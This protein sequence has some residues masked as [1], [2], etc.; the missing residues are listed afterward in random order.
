MEVVDLEQGPSRR[1]AG[2]VLRFHPLFDGNHRLFIIFP[3]Q[4]YS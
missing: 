4:A 1:N 3:I 2:P